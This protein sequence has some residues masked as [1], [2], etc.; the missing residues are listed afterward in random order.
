MTDERTIGDIPRADPA[1]PGTAMF[2]L[3]VALIPLIHLFFLLSGQSA[4][5]DGF[6][7]G[8]DSYM[9]LVR[10]EQLYQTGAWY[11]G[12]LARSNWPYGEVQNWTRPADVV[13]LSGALLLE[14]WLGFRQALYWWGSATAPLLH[15]ATALALAWMVAPRF[16]RSRQFLVVLLFLVQ[17]P[18]WQHGIF[19]RTDHHMFIFLAF[20]LA[21]GGALRVMVGPLRPRDGLL[22]GALAG[23]GLWLTIEFLVVLAIIFA[24]FTIRWLVDGAGLARRYLWHALGLVAMVAVALVAERPPDAWLAAE[25]DRISVVHLL[26]ALVAAGFWAAAAALEARGRAGEV[27]R[28]ALIAA[29]GAVTAA[30]VMLLVYPRFFAGPFVEFS[31]ELWAIS[32]NRTAEFQPLM[33]KSVADL[34]SA[35]MK[36]GPALIAV[37]YL[38]YST[39]RARGRNLADLWL[40]IALGLL[41]YLPL[42]LMMRRFAP[43]AAILLGLV[44]AD[45]VARLLDRMSA[46]RSAIARLG[47]AGLL[48]AV[49]FGHVA[50]GGALGRLLAPAQAEAGGPLCPMDALI[51]E[52]NRPETV[53]P[54]RHAVLATPNFGPMILYL[55]DHAV[56]TTL[57][58]RNSAGQLDAF[59]IYTAT[60]WP[61]ARRLIEQRGIDLV[62]ACIGKETYTDLSAGPG[63]LDSRLRRGEA[64]DWLQPLELGGAARKLYRIYR[65][66]PQVG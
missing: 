3:A 8:Q 12:T 14:P 43:V 33:P 40:L 16:E 36:I 59:R 7:P 19:G 9:R 11:D 1:A 49:V 26:M 63:T 45:L 2:F 46:A 37:P 54:G 34:G 24:A 32:T 4:V 18:V 31:D 53:G 42:T 6:L 35:I 65:V 56:V 15:V 52:L 41:L 58:A 20:A 51:D 66:S 44:M 23:F 48:V 13:M 62:V 50:V 61:S 21:L 17:I 28:R 57:Y 55:T 60:D 29:V 30:G 27:R 5:L 38:V 10:V 39:W 25:Y 47:S 64:P 22:A